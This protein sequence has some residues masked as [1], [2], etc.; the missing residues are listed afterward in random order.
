ML[1][2]AC[3]C[4]VIVHL[5]YSL[6]RTWTAWWTTSVLVGP[7]VG[8]IKDEQIIVNRTALLG[9][10][11]E[12]HRH[13]SHARSGRCLCQSL[14]PTETLHQYWMSASSPSRTENISELFQEVSSTSIISRLITYSCSVLR[15]SSLIGVYV[16]TTLMSIIDRIESVSC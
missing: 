10:A 12:F 13:H 5:C 16:M 2:D 6:L 11:L 3:W 14:Q 4:H 9:L 8:L 1:T 15:C 7:H